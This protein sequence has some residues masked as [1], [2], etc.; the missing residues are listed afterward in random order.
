M[1]TEEL[2][3]YRDT[4]KLCEILMRYQVGGVPKGDHPREMPKYVKHGV[5]QQTLDKALAALDSIYIA[6]SHVTG[7]ASA[8][9]RYLEN[10]GCARSRIRLM[11][12]MEYLTVRQQTN[13][14]SLVDKC[15][16]Q[17]TAWRK[18]TQSESCDKQESEERK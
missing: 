2:R 4:F 10:L 18:S 12:E 11:G 14:M 1:L 7:R 16:K 3:I 6:N 15:A 5:F 8:L 9:G 17:A 13:L